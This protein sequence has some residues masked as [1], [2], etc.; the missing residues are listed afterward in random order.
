VFLSRIA[1]WLAACVLLSFGSLAFGAA[2]KLTSDDPSQ[3]TENDVYQILHN[4]PWTKPVKV[5]SSA[6]SAGSLNQGSTPGNTSSNG[7][8]GN[9]NSVPNGAPGAMGRRGMGRSQRTYNS[10]SG[11]SNGSSRSPSS[12]V[13]I[14]WQSALP[15]QIAAAKKDKADADVSSLKGMNEYVIALIGL[16]D[17]AIGG[18]AASIDSDTTLNAEIEQRMCDRVKASATLL[19]GGHDA[20]KPDKVEVNQGK[21]GRILIYFA[22]S[23]PILLS[24]KS[25]EFRLIGDH[26]QLRKKFVLKEMT[27]QGKLVL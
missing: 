17:T 2:H 15:V 18:R 25:V 3:W 13:E 16:P 26:V 20:L 23:D 22:K 1:P 24:D 4:S 21:D 7:N 6:A 10:G 5:N 9:N 14:Q 12:E 11:S 19:R 8:W 27:Y